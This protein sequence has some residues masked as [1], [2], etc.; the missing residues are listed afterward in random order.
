MTEYKIGIDVG[1]TF[2]DFLLT[3][4]DGE[5][6]IYKVLST[7]E[8]PSVGL[9]NGLSEMAKDRELSLEDFIKKVSTIVHGTTVT[10]N[11]VLTRKGAKT[12]LLT[13]KGVR[14]A[15]EMRRGIREEQYNNRF[16]NVKPL[17]P[18]YLRFPIEGR[19]NYE[20][21][22]I[23]ALN[24]SDVEDAIELFTKEGVEA[25]AICFMNSFANTAHEVEAAKLINDK[26][27]EAYLTVSA[28]FL[29]SIRFYDRIS[30]TAL[31]S[32]VG[33]ILRSYLTS[34]IRKLDQI[35]FEGVLLIMQSN[36]GVVSPGSAIDNAAV[37]LLS[38]PAAGPVAGIEYTSIQGYNDCITVDMGGTSFDAALIKD[39]TPL[40]TTE[41]E[42]NRLRIALPMLGIVTIGAG[43][44]S[45][46]WVDEGGLLRMGPQSAGS[47]P[48][49]ACYDL[50][51]ELPTCTDADLI[52]GY[53]DK[54]FFAGGK[55]P[56]SYEKG[57]KAIQDN[58]ADP[59]GM[60]VVEAAAG[61]YRIINVNMASGV[62]EVSVKR[63]HDPREF[64]L[65]VAGGAGPVHACMIAQELEIPV[66]IIPKESSIFCAA[67]MLMSDLKHN[68]VRTY[69]TALNQ[70][71]L[72]KFQS[73]FAEME[74]E[75]SALLHSEHIPEEAMRHIYS[76]DLRYI[77]Q[78]H[79]VNVEVTKEEIVRGDLAGMV[80]RFHPEH[81]RLFGYSLEE[82]GTPV[83]LINLRLLSVGE[84]I[85]PR[86]KQEDYDQEDPSKALKKQ[87]WVYLPSEGRFEDIPVYDGHKL[88][89]GNKI[90][91][92][93]LIEQVNTTTFVTPDYSV[94]CDQY[95][96]Y[97][98]Y[99]KTMEAEMER[100]L[101]LL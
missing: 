77:K 4:S 42:I 80:A 19:L 37:T 50:G 66:M 100:K 55:I 6:E 31:N 92:P 58:I 97:T 72:A 28:E 8:D 48:G 21:D 99:L 64:P 87:R 61:M 90:E 11:A 52:L 73:L 14:D 22:V 12:G 5:S 25:V 68:F 51:G 43:G 44:G 32:Y 59:L 82:Q 18:R 3:S 15:L 46:G 45:I 34:L 47:N 26:M 2:T 95:G 33:P 76:L 7:P 36:G 39:K 85:K 49:P 23:T 71:D 38:G 57:E 29:P 86:F 60:D 16:T 101:R 69:S 53:L 13:T 35:G 9:M 93:A 78:Y 24:T 40:V 17:V 89:F 75:A 54:D 94:L 74:D 91:G 56:L 83:E 98:M 10:T 79:E 20:G 96:S 88:A 62:R 67:G 84:T 41:G 81:N 27:P 30:T 65:V 1:G 70:M 63:G